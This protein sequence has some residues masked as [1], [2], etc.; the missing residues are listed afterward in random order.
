MGIIDNIP[1]KIGIQ[2]C[3]Q[4]KFLGRISIKLNVDRWNPRAWIPLCLWSDEVY[5][6][7]AAS[8][9]G[10]TTTETWFMKKRALV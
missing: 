1:E 7:G 5:D 4:F 9:G 10:H 6:R 3:D 2:K 8:K